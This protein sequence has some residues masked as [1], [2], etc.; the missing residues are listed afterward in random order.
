MCRVVN[1]AVRLVARTP[2]ARWTGALILLS[3][4]T[5]R[6][7]RRLQIPVLIPQL[8]P[9]LVVFSDAPAR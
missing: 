5:R 2:V 6:T 1:P 7:A 8:G 9:N 4:V 3:F